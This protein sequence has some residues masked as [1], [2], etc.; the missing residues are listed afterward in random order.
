MGESKKDALRD[1][2]DILM[3]IR[4]S[5]VAKRLIWEIPV[6]MGNLSYKE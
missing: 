1:R 6:N 2:F 4:L 5:G 3:K